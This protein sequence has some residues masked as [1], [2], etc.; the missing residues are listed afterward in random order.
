[1]PKLFGDWGL[2]I[3]K[4]LIVLYSFFEAYPTS[5]DP[6]IYMNLAFGW[7]AEE[8]KQRLLSYLMY[9]QCGLKPSSQLLAKR[10][11]D[12]EAVT[13]NRCMDIPNVTKPPWN[14]NNLCNDSTSSLNTNTTLAINLPQSSDSLASLLQGTLADSSGTS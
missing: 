6:D 9:I 1:M 8:A 7:N 14:F 4:Y 2:E 12:N 11:T 13:K 5:P 3:T 10:A